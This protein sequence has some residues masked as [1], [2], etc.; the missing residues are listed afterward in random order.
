MEPIYPALNA[1]GHDLERALPPPDPACRTIVGVPVRDEEETLAAALGALRGQRDASGGRLDPASYEVLL[2]V[3]NSKDASARLASSLGANAPDFRLHVLEVDLP[4]HLSHVGA[5]RRLAMDIADRR[6][7]ALERERGLI[8]STDADTLV[9]RDWIANMQ[10]AV[11]DGADAIGGRITFSAAGLRAL[12]LP[13]RRAYLQDVGY[14]YLAA[15]LTARLAPR[16]EDPWPHHFQNFGASMAATA[17]AYRRAGGLP[18][19]A[20]LEDVAFFEALERVDARIR[21]PV[22]VRVQTSARLCGKT[23][24][25]LAVQLRCWGAAADCQEIRYVPSAA[26]V[27]RL[28]MGREELRRA[29]HTSAAN[30]LGRVSELLGIE[31]ETL[32]CLLHGS[33]TFGALWQAVEPLAEAAVGEE[34]PIAQAIRELRLTLASLRGSSLTDGRLARTGPIDSSHWRYQRDGAAGRPPAG[35]GWHAPH[36]QSAGS[37]PL[38][39]ASAPAAAALED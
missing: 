29:W 22:D 9:D 20:A 27:A 18:V 11:A 25:G 21:R 1:L 37:P 12:P 16:P 2:L 33:A 24:F 4:D 28:A 15:E 10:R 38:P 7:A 17:G 39:A 35:R 36:R 5:A 26:A 19:R 8:A 23:G 6:F 30:R 32:S 13:I 14:R 31:T 34:V 3:N